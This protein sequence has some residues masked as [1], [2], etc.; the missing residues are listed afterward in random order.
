MTMHCSKCGGQTVYP[1]NSAG[2]W[3]CERCQRE[4]IQSWR[5]AER[6]GFPAVDLFPEAQPPVNGELFE[7]GGP[8]RGETC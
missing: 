1:P 2:P 3:R 8:D 6:R 5:K 4:R 7:A